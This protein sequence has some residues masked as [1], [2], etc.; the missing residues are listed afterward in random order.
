MPASEVALALKAKRSVI[1]LND[2][3]LSQSFFADL[4]KEYVHI[5]DQAHEAIEQVKKILLKPTA[6]EVEISKAGHS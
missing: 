6:K 2:N 1:L 5:V 4:G 3:K